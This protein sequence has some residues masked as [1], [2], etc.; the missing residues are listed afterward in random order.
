[1]SISLRLVLAIVVGAHGIGHVL[2]LLPLVSGVDW[3]QPAQ[4]W[5]LGEGGLAKVSGGLIWLV[6][7]AGFLAAAFGIFQQTD[8][9][10]TA[11]IVSAAVSTV[12]LI[13]FWRQPVPPPALSALVFNLLILV[14]LLVFHWPSSVQLGG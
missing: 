13:L 9:W 7:L 8:W 14:S 11:A 2:F 6:A 1:M 3:G 10:Q 4:S 5:L 12:G